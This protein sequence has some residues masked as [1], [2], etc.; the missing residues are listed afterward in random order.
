MYSLP[1][2]A[3]SRWGYTNAS[4]ESQPRGGGGKLHA[5][6]QAKRARA[7]GGL[8]I[9]GKERKP[10]AVWHH[11]GENSMALR[12]GGD[13]SLALDAIGGS[14]APSSTACSVQWSA[15]KIA[16]SHASHNTITER[17]CGMKREWL[18]A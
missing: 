17:V 12:R 15:S 6:W 18:R 9:A 13:A 2:E 11:V 5:A 8:I 3:E 1:T 4:T 10:R 7:C 16:G 14:N